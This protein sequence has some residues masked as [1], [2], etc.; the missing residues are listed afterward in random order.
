MPPEG[1]PSHPSKEILELREIELLA[2]LFVELGIKKIRLTGGEPLL[3]EKIVALVSS[4]SKISGLQ[5]LALTTNG[6]KLSPLALYLKE[7]GLSSINISIDSLNPTRFEKITRQGKLREVLGGIQTALSCGLPV[8]LNVV[9]LSD[10]T[11][12]EVGEFCSLAKR[13]PIEIRFIEFMPLCGSGFDKNKGLSIPLLH[14]WIEEKLS[15]LPLERGSNPSQ[16]YAIQG[17]P[18]RIGIIASLSEPFCSDCSRLR[19]TATGMIRPCLFSSQETD[20]RTPLRQGQTDEELKQIILK[21]A[22]N[23]PK[24]HEEFLE[25]GKPLPMIRSIGG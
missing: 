23:K 17:S 14:E 3:R 24:G 1:L 13:L 19:L 11:C 7:A 6:S 25:T 20:L 4:L 2:R 22:W 9:A 18:G 15:L 5:E 10:L 16:T 12:E 8:K 21:A